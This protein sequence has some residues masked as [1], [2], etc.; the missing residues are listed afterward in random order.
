MNAG[1]M[2]KRVFSCNRF[3]WLN[4]NAGKHHKQLAGI[5]DLG[6]VNPGVCPVKIVSCFQIHHDFFQSRISRAFSD[7]VERAFRL[8]RPSLDRGQG[9][10]NSQPQIVVAMHGEERIAKINMLPQISN[11]L[12]HFFR[13]GI[14]D[15]V[16]NVD[17]GSARV[18]CDL[19]DL[20]QERKLAPCGIFRGKF[21]CS[22]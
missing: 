21:H 6:C 18:N 11:D 1:F 9:V 10:C 16:R 17:Y 2:R 3:V 5:N 20:G 19:K 7:S 8:P 15:G 13:L 4:L 14:S 12:F 22:A